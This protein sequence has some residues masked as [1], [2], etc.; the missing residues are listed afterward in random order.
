MIKSKVI[1]YNHKALSIENLEKLYN[2][3][4]LFG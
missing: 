1:N 2:E 4:L 3:N